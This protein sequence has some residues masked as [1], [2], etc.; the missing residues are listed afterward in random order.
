M[1]RGGRRQGAGRK[2]GSKTGVKLP[3]VSAEIKHELRELA[4]EHTGAAL[5][6]LV[7]I[8]KMGESEAARVSAANALLDSGYGKPL[9]QIE[10]GGPGQ[11]SRM[12]DEELDAFL[13]DDDLTEAPA[14]KARH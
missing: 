12:S 7:R 14:A 4:R 1:S 13:A 10:S 9:Q 11:F 3:P 8:C 6:A 5:D 2:R